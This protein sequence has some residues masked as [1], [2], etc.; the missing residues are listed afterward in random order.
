MVDREL[1]R[2][3]HELFDHLKIP[4]H[5]APG[6][7][8]AECA[9]LQ[10]AGIVDAV[11]SDDGDAFMFGCG[12][13]IKAHKVGKD[14]IKDMIKVFTIDTIQRK[15]DMDAESF[16]LFALLAGGD[17]ATEGLRGCGSQTAREVVKRQHGLAKEICHA[18]QGELPAWRERL[19]AVLKQQ[20]HKNIE[21]P[22]TFPDWKALGYYRDPAVSEP[23]KLSNL[24]GL[25]QGWE[26]RIDQQKLRVILRQRSNFWTRGYLKHIAPIFFVRALARAG[27]EQREQNLQFGVQV[28]RTRKVK[29]ND[30]ED[31][32]PARAEIKVTFSPLPAVEIDLSEQPPGEDWSIFAA[33]D[34]TPYDPLQNV[35]C[36]VLE[37]FLKHGLPDGTLDT[38]MAPTS[39]RKRKARS[40]GPVDESGAP[41]PNPAKRRKRNNDIEASEHILSLVA[42]NTQADAVGRQTAKK[43]DKHN[44]M[45]G[46]LPSSNMPKKRGRPRK[47]AA[48]EP[49][50]TTSNRD[51]GTTKGGISRSDRGDNPQPTTF[52]L[53]RAA[54]LALPLQHSSTEVVDLCDDSS[55]DELPN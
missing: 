3:L 52:Q 10:Q 29:K 20:Y 19:S 42:S 39:K 28:K 32:P 25:R 18:Q 4:Y 50:L 40:D 22:A 36:G 31:E 35:E 15:H 2:L 44:L 34:G 45:A 55:G 5:Q 27:P 46:H 43:P 9:R 12:T 24:R 1:T 54:L 48:T 17:Y 26:Q 21:V 14:R 33:K 49:D 7:A 23:E 38:A 53:P 51:K 30:D 47:A 8:E 16:V 41:V 37:C 6:E 11:W 13:L